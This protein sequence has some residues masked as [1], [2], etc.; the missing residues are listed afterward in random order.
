MELTWTWAFRVLR[1]GKR[2]RVRFGFCFAI[3]GFCGIALEKSR[4]FFVGLRWRRADLGFFYGIALEKSR[5]SVFFWGCVG[6]E[7]I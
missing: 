3:F 7:Q 6:E 2:E 4:C 1:E 5:F